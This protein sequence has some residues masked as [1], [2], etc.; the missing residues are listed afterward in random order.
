MT[1]EEL[2][3]QYEPMI[4]RL[5]RRNH[6]FR[7]HDEYIQLSKIAMWDVYHKFNPTKGDL[8]P[9][10]YVAI[11]RAIQNQIRREVKRGQYVNDEWDTSSIVAEERRQAEEFVVELAS[12]RLRS[13][14][15]QLKPHEQ[16]LFVSAFLIEKKNDELMEEFNCSRAT[17]LK[18]KVRL[19]KKCKE[20][21][22]VLLAEESCYTTTQE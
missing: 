3:E 6:V 19:M 8:A 4:Y 10:F 14:V 15:Q 5:M 16:Q 7:D 17:I 9:F 20:L 13:I 2:V 1:F 22:Q 12:E 21:A 18:R 11:N